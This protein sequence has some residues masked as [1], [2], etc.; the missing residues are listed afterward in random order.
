M[1]IKTTAFVGQVDDINWNTDEALFFEGAAEVPQPFDGV[2]GPINIRLTLITAIQDV[3]NNV[4]IKFEKASHKRNET[5][6]WNEFDPVDGLRVFKNHKF[7]KWYTAKGNVARGLPGNKT[8]TYTDHA[9][10][11]S[12][13]NA[14]DPANASEVATRWDDDA[15]GTNHAAFDL[16]N[17]VYESGA[18]E[19]Y[20]WIVGDDFAW[21]DGNFDRSAAF[22]YYQF[23][24]PS[25]DDFGL[26]SCQ[27]RC[28]FGGSIGVKFSPRF[29]F[30][31]GPEYEQKDL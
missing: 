20:R 27:A 18:D 12:I 7:R 26:Y 8:D 25:S 14:W 4:M 9:Y 28:D 5:Y 6:N 31:I 19:G 13:Y 30:Y 3:R 2:E 24:N 10:P 15:S 29:G 21:G 16:Q 11:G 23:D 1:L 22:V 17:P